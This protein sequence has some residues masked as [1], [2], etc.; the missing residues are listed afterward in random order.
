M[1]FPPV[2]PAANPEQLVELREAPQK[3]ELNLLRSDEPIT[4][5]Q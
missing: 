2:T 5:R 4:S 1:R 3:S